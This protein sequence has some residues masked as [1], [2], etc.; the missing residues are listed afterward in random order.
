M[1]LM[2]WLRLLW[3]VCCLAVLACPEAR[4]QE[5]EATE[6]STAD[7]DAAELKRRGDVAMDNLDYAGA[8]AHY[9]RAY[10]LHPDPALLYNR[11]RAHQARGEFVEALADFETFRETAPPEL[12][13][14]VPR[15]PG[16]TAEVRA[17]IATLVVVCRVQG[18][19]VTV[20]GAAIGA[21]P[22]RES[23]PIS[24]GEIE[25]EATAEGYHPFR[26]H[27]RAVG[28]KTIRVPIKLGLVET[29][30][31]LRVQGPADAEV[32]V[33]GQHV[34]RAPA[35]LTVDPGRHKVQLRRPAY[36][37]AQA[38]VVIE[39]GEDRRV[40]IDPKEKKPLTS[41]WWFWTTIGVGIAA[42]AT[43]AALLIE[44][45]PSSGEHFTPGTISGPLT[46][47]F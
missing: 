9:T 18:A 40:T 16:L 15:L 17:R 1:L 22:I 11:G 2:R 39:A 34:G 26:T 28:G 47:H 32:W 3:A 42:G 45:P 24:E 46:V 38:T 4:A 25:I 14:R 6:E 10:A 20:G 31:L 21:C 7:H 12:L 27:V 23:I 8:I 37:E 35:E 33:D 41:R 19:E 13:A 30:G 5:E 44:K 36:Q 43:T 29:T